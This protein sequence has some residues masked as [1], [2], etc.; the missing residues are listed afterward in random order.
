MELTAGVVHLPK[1]LDGAS[2]RAL[3]RAV[4]DALESDAAVVSFVGCDSETFCAGVNVDAV[5]D[6]RQAMALFAGLFTVL[7]S[8]TKPLVAVV[9]GAAIGGGLGL[10]CACDWVI[11][12]PRATFG[13]PELLWGLAPATIWPIVSSRMTA[14]EAWRWTISAHTR[15]ATAAYAAGIVDEVVEVDALERTV[16]RAAQRLGRLECL[17]LSR[18]R[19]WA[20]DCHQHPLADAVSMGAAI[21]AQLAVRPQVRRRWDA[22]AKGEAP[23]SV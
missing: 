7:Q 8:S 22:Y 6:D 5:L 1:S 9:D 4:N 19:E 2:V 3:A 11:A 16:Q 13:L 12:S 20:R 23:W 21:T 14:H 15:P 10:A 17:A 18:M